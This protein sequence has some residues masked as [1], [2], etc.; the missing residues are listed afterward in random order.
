MRIKNSA[1]LISLLAVFTFG[2]YSIAAADTLQNAEQAIAK[3]D[4]STAIIHLKNQLKQTPKNAQARYLL[5]DIYLQ[6]GKLDS[7]IKELGR[8]HE[9]APDNTSY[10]FHYAEILQA[11][12]QHKKTLAILQNTPLTDKQQESRR[13]NYMGYAHL[14]LKQLADAKQAFN[15][16]L[17]LHE[18]IM[19]YNGLA[20]LAMIE[21]EPDL[22]EQLLAKSLAIEADNP[23]T[24]QL[25]AKLAIFNKQYEQALTLYNELIEKNA[26]NLILYLE[27]ASILSILEQD[28]RAKADLDI[29]LSKVKNHPQA[30][31]ILA[32]ILLRERSFSGAQAAAQQVVNVMP[33]HMPAVLVLGAANFALKNYNQAEEYLTIYLSADPTNLKAQNLL[34][35]VYLAQNK[36]K[37]AL[38]I[39]EGIPAEQRNNSPL[40]LLTLGSVYIAKGDTPKGIEILSRAQALAPDNLDIKKRLIAAQFQS[41]NL[42]DAISELEQLSASGQVQSQSN[43]LLIISYIKQQQFAKADEKVKQL[44]TQT[45]DD[46]TLQNLDALIEQLK[47]NSEKAMALYRAIIEKD[48][49]NTAAYMGLAR[50]AAIDSNWQESEQYFKQVL[51]INPNEFKAY[52]GLVAV[53][54]KQNKPQLAEQYFL[55]AIE[56]SKDDIPSQLVIASLLSQWYLSKQ[57]PEKVLALTEMLA[58]QHPDNNLIRSSLARAQLLNKQNKRAERTLKNIITFDKSDVKHRILLAQIISQDPDRSDEALRLLDDAQAVEPEN[59]A[60]YTLKTALLIRQKHYEEAILVAYDAQKQFPESILGKILE[61][62]IYRAQ[63][64]Y[65]KALPIYLQSYQQQPDRKILSASISLLLILNQRD[66]AISMLTQAIENDPEDTDSLFK[67]ASLYHESQNMDKAEQYYNQTLKYD[68]NHIV[69]LNN[70]AWIYYEQ[71]IKRAVTMAEK[72]HKQAPEAAAI[73]DT[74]GYFLVLD[75]Q[76]QA[77]LEFIEQAAQAIPQDKDIQY[78]LAL[79]YEK[80]GQRNKARTILEPLMDSE[81]AFSEVEK[82]KALYQKIK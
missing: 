31:F 33:Q 24:L 4:Y 62:D 53:A 36:I 69:T 75:G 77:G 58:K 39:L 3:K 11:A 79:A 9:Y 29:I 7:A 38:L 16:A 46:T 12:G 70:L 10:L 47:G 8:A 37:Q 17:K 23:N 68:P 14:R 5:G 65:E 34:A 52:L 21:Q 49:D 61:A 72:A 25:K 30:N 76:Y 18:N 78:H 35:Y 32:Q 51:Q 13:Q 22:A 45:P 44:L 20:S 54:E 42:D 27:R 26:G 63:K 19:S 67:L 57:Q 50:M 71:D 81:T 66:K 74:Y 73:K 59:Q 2:S 82:A 80:L 40:I 55:E 43:Y 48:K 28:D 64:D 60:L 6:T 56:Q 1:L 41:G 15:E